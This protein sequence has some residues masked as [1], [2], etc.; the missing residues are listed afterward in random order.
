MLVVELR[1]ECGLPV[2]FPDVFILDHWMVF[3][4]PTLRGKTIFYFK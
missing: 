2:S 3:G 1:L 4:A